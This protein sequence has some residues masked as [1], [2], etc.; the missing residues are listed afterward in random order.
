M[1]HIETSSTLPARRRFAPP[2]H[3]AGPTRYWRVSECDAVPCT[4][5]WGV[6]VVECSD[7]PMA[8]GLAALEAIPPM[9]G[10][11]DTGFDFTLYTGDLNLGSGPV[12]TALGNHDSYNV[13]QDAQHAIGGE[14]AEQFSWNNNHLAVW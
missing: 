5:P 14:L 6:Q 9:T 11:Q 3:A 7:T 12:Y 13:Q 2:L 8:L 1:S 10:T 4:A